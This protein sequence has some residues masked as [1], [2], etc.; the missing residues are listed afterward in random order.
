V[1]PRERG[2]AAAGLPALP[3][4]WFP[5]EETTD[6]RGVSGARAMR[7]PACRP[8]PPWFPK[9]ET[10]HRRGVSGARAMRRSMYRPSSQWFPE[11][12]TTHRRGM[13]GARAKAPTVMPSIPGAPLFAFTRF[14]AAARFSGSRISSIMVLARG[15]P[16]FPPR[17]LPSFV[18]LRRRWRRY[19]A[20]GSLGFDF[21][22]GKSRHNPRYR[23]VRRVTNAKKFRAGLASLKD[24]IKK[25]RSV[26][27]PELTATLG[28]KLQG[29][30]NY[31]GVIGNSKR[32]WTFAWH[33]KRLIYKWLN[34]LKICLRRP[35]CTRSCPHEGDVIH[36]RSG[37]SCGNHAVGL[38]RPGAGHHHSEA[39]SSGGDDVA[40]R[41]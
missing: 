17:R 33:A 13:S 40:R 35:S 18:R 20:H 27:L 6:R 31:Y 11:E 39:R 9:E 14:H 32:N 28:R 10:T 29:Y 15:S 25:S 12:E 37:D 23:R 16:C 4:Q 34:C 8:F 3:S 21:H 41:F 22:W 26:P 19:R 5:E 36:S 7:R 24:W 2:N 1:L 38:R 30:R